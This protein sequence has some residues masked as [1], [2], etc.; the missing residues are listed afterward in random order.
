MTTKL[1]EVN[2]STQKVGDIIKESNSKIDLKSIPN[3]SK[4]INSMRQMIGSLTNSRNSLKI[5]RDESNRATFSG[6]PIQ[7]SKDDKI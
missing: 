5:T 1:D 6:V 3:S 7:I 2:K 4:N